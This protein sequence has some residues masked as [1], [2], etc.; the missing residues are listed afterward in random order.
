MCFDDI[1][2]FV[3]PSS[4]QQWQMMVLY[5]SPSKHVIILVVT[6]TGKRDTPIFLHVHNWY[7]FVG[8]WLTKLNLL[9]WPSG[10]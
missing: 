2:I 1:H 8:G 5:A 7:I 3:W 6:T 10:G 4:Q 9:P